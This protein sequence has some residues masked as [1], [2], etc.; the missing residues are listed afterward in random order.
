MLEFINPSNGSFLSN[1]GD[2][3]EDEFGN[4]LPIL[5]GI[6]RFSIEKNYTSNFGFQWNI[7]SKTQIDQVNN[8]NGSNQ[9]EIRFFTTTD[10]KAE[11]M[12]GLDVLEAG[13]GAG[14]FSN[15]ILSQTNA[16]LHSFD[17]SEA[18][19]ANRSN[20]KHFDASRFQ[21]SQASIYEIPYSDNSFD[22]VIC[23]GVL[24]H[25]PDFESAIKSLITKAKP[26]GEIVVDFYRI[27]GW[28]TKVHAKYLLRP[29]TRKL[30]HERL[31]FLISK[32]IRWLIFLFDLLC[33]IKLGFLTR[34]LP[35]ADLRNFPHILDSKQRMEWAILDTF[36]MFSPKYDNPQKLDKVVDMFK[37][38]NAKVTFSGLIKLNEL[39]N[40]INVIR[41][42]KI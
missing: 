33:F 40:Q 14:R 41:A 10:W 23:F 22:K 35:M 13:S 2:Y 17:Y 20:N 26:G 36:D 42:I 4:I 9:S 24:Q 34:F 30:P 15:I 39:N 18:V 7:F 12:D 6:P 25:T 1:K 21:L 32:N 16:S 29:I 38:M 19:D 11:E 5:N 8:K 28:W 37:K 27:N 31:L 3:L